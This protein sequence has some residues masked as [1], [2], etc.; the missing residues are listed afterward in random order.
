MASICL[1]IQTHILC[2]HLGGSHT[3]SLNQVISLECTDE[4]FYR[5]FHLSTAKILLSY[6]LRTISISHSCKY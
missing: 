6:S 5:G 4:Q 1:R 2:F 3:V